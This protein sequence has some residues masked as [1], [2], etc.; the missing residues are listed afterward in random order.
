M[1]WWK[2]FLIM[3]K[4]IHLIVAILVSGGDSGS[5]M[6]Y[7]TPEDGEKNKKRKDKSQTQE[8]AVSET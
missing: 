3:G 1:K 4:V 7:I 6:P 2:P 5:S 8:K